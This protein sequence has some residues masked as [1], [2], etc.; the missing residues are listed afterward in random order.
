MAAVRVPSGTGDKT[1]W[2]GLEHPVWVCGHVWACMGMRCGWVGGWEM[3]SRVCDSSWLLCL[4]T[5]AELQCRFWSWWRTASPPDLKSQLTSSI[6]PQTPVPVVGCDLQRVTAGEGNSMNVMALNLICFCSYEQQEDSHVT[7]VRSCD[8]SRRKS[9]VMWQW[10]E[11][12]SRSS[13]LIL[14]FC[15]LSSSGSISFT[16]PIIPPK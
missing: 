2:A 16:N 6:L 11:R 1:G 8:S 9:W 4:C 5:P 7:V 10:Q 3:W 12:A 13:T 14:S 15:P